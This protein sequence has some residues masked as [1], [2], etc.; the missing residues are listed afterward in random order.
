MSLFTSSIYIYFY[1]SI[2]EKIF[3][4]EKGNRVTETEKNKEFE[5]EKSILPMASTTL[6]TVTMESSTSVRFWIF[7]NH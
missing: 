2:L 4:G 6:E 5:N 3:L 7:C 1:S